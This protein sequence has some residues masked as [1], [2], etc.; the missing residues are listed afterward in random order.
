M[1]PIVPFCNYSIGSGFGLNTPISVT[2][3]ILSDTPSIYT[4]LPIFIVPYFTLTKKN[5]PLLGSNQE[6][7]IDANII[8]SLSNLF[9]TFATYFFIVFV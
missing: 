6:S 1:K 3:C 2:S 5:T 8:L 7:K 4:K 9:L